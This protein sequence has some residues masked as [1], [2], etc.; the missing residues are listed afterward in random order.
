[1]S[2]I[3]IKKIERNVCC[4]YDHVFVCSM[5]SICYTSW[6]KKVDANGYKRKI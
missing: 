2:V 5:L 4:N 6:S 3:I 1:M